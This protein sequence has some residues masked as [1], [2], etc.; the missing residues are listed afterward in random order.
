MLCLGVFCF[1]VCFTLFVLLHLCVLFWSCL[2][3][4]G[5]QVHSGFVL[6]LYVGFVVERCPLFGLFSGL[7]DEIFVVYVSCFVLIAWL[8]SLLLS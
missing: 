7:F 1:V 6:L 8:L 2:N 4:I 3:A 5:L